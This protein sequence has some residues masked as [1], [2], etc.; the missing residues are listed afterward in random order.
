ML[1]RGMEE[2]EMVR[3]HVIHD[4]APSVFTGIAKESHIHATGLRA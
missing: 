1:V 4:T 3:G 2:E